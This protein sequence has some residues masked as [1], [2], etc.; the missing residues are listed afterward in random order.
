MNKL[1]SEFILMSPL[2]SEVMG[3]IVR[4]LSLSETSGGPAFQG[5]QRKFKETQALVLGFNSKEF[6]RISKNK[7]PGD[8]WNSIRFPIGS[9]G[10]MEFVMKSKDFHDI[11]WR[12]SWK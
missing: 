6:L 7:F 1:C 3:A 9:L 4:R 12:I 5:S 8:P 2:S 10:S 11:P